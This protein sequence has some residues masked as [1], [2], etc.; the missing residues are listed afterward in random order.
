M[1]LYLEE[2]EEDLEQQHSVHYEEERIVEQH[3]LSD[4]LRRALARESDAHQDK[5]DDG[6]HSASD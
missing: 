5:T 6:V 3:L 2:V 4:V 1:K